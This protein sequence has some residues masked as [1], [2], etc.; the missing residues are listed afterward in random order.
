MFTDWQN[1]TV[2]NDIAL[3][4]KPPFV[5]PQRLDEKQPQG[6]TARL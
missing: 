2:A 5:M 4:N 6:V 3:K 1:V